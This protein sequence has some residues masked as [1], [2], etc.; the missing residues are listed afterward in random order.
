MPSR[1]KFSSDCGQTRKA[2]KGASGRGYFLGVIMF[3]EGTKAPK[4]LPI[5]AYT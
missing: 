4:A 5:E 3:F 1:V 2:L